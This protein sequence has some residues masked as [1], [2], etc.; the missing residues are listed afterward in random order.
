MEG[1]L[2]IL[3][4]KHMRAKAMSLENAVDA[5]KWKQTIRKKTNEIMDS[6]ER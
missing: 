2:D 3:P 1:G 6:F 4:S 5:D